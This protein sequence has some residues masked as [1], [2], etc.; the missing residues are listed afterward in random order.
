MLVINGLQAILRDLNDN[1]G[2]AMLVEQ[3]RKANYKA[4][5]TNNQHGGHDV[6]CKPRIAFVFLNRISFLFCMD[7]QEN[8]LQV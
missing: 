5:V 4:F 3:T 2:A 1:S 7:V 6:T 8:C